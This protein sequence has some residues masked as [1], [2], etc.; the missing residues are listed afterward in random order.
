MHCLRVALALLGLCGPLACLADAG[1]YTF[2]DDKGMV[3]L[4]NVPDNERYQRLGSEAGADASDRVA[5][6]GVVAT[7]VR[8]PY[9]V[10]VAQVA[11]RFGI[12]PALLHAVISVESGYNARAVSKRGAAGLMQL[13][14]ETA[15]RFGVADVFDPAENVRAGAQYLTY[16]LKLFDNDLELALAAYNAGE[17]AVIKYGRHIPPYRETAAYVPKVVGFYQKL[18]LPM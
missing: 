5:V 3:H 7:A 17:T 6:D 18:R 9:D 10:L 4:S 1:V 15:R 16:L 2:V 13:M 11:G 12:E 14:P 8:H